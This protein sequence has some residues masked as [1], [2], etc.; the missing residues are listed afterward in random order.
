MPCAWKVQNR[1][2]QLVTIFPNPQINQEYIKAALTNQQTNYTEQSPFSFMASQNYP[3]FCETRRFTAVLTNAQHL[4]LSWATDSS[5]PHPII[6]I[7]SLRSTLILPSRLHLQV[8]PHQN[9]LHISVF[10]RTC[11]M[12][13]STHP[14]TF[15]I[16]IIIWLVE[17]MK[18]PSC[19]QFSLRPKY[20]SQ[21]PIPEHPQPT[22]PLNIQDPTFI[23]M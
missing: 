14:P 10:C 22:F 3:T 23:L 16:P 1:P 8:L 18:L 11:H 9:P 2:Q 15:I 6:L 4:P 7:P 19:Y 5:S 12:P 17:T 20:L 21:H 13:H